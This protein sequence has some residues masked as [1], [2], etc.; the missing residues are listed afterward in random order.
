V[1]D[2][3]AHVVTAYWGWKRGKGSCSA[4][5][6]AVL[7]DRIFGRAGVFPLSIAAYVCCRICARLLGAVQS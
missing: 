6:R 4:R 3:E 5:T 1:D 7:F 2:V